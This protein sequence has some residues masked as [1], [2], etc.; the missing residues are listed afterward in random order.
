MDLKSL[1]ICK[2]KPSWHYPGGSTSWN[3]GFLLEY[4][5]N[6]LFLWI[7]KLLS[8]VLHELHEFHRP[9]TVSL[10]WSL[11][12][13]HALVVTCCYMWLQH[14]PIFH[15]FPIYSHVSRSQ[16]HNSRRRSDN[17][18]QNQMHVARTGDLASA[19]RVIHNISKLRTARDRRSAAVLTLKVCDLCVLLG[20]SGLLEM[21]QHCQ[22]WHFNFHPY[23]L[24]NGILGGGVVLKFHFKIQ[25]LQ[26]CILNDQYSSSFHVKIKYLR[27]APEELSASI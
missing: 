26:S 3:K 12:S 9:T 7:P 17:T 27:L 4:S 19:Q 10:V 22:A 24:K 11:G 13:L 8:I 18:Y 20:P 25:F 14:L 16:G 6:I 15:Y 5:V 21:M 23:P 1:L 2:V